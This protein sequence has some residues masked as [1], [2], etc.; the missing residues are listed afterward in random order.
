MNQELCNGPYG[1]GLDGSNISLPHKSYVIS[2]RIAVQIVIVTHTKGSILSACA[3]LGLNPSYLVIG[4][5]E[6]DQVIV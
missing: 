4:T 1:M 5:L 3:F 6:M 2:I